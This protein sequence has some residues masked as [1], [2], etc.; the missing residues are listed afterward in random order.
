MAKRRFWRDILGVFNSNVFAVINGMLLAI[1]LTRLLGVEGF[2]IYTALLIVPIIVVSLTHLGIRGSSIF[3]IGN[4]KFDEDQMVSSIMVLLVGSSIAGIL[5][6]IIAYYYVDNENFTIP[7]ISMVLL[8]IPVRLAIIYLGGIFLGRDEIRKSNT[9]NWSVN[10]FN[11]VLAIGFVWWL[12]WGV[13]G[14]VIAIQGICTSRAG[15]EC[16]PQTGTACQ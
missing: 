5:L 11:L 10:L 9:L 4:K 12:D 1:L 6:S 7:L 15:L 16:Q 8:I 13:T 14:A 3:H 2:G